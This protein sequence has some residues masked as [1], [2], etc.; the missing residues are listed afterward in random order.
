MDFRPTTRLTTML[1]IERDVCAQRRLVRDLSTLGYRVVPVTSADQGVDLAQRFRFDTV[2]C[3]K[4]LPGLKWIEFSERVRHLAGAVLL[5]DE[6]FD[7]QH[8]ENARDLIHGDPEPVALLP[9]LQRLIHH[10]VTDRESV[11][12][13]KTVGYDD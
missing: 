9:K 7:P 6:L 1:V 8:L 4:T 5:I 3:S 10:L 2:L 12:E 11:G 13:I